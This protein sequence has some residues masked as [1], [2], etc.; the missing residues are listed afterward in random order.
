[1]AR[2]NLVVTMSLKAK[3]ALISGSSRGIARAIAL[4]LA[5]RAP[6]LR[7]HYFQDRAPA[8]GA[9]TAI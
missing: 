1:M 5:E 2:L 8:E 7:V 6:G 3:T 9:F 4:K